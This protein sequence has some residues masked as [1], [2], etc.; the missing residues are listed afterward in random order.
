MEYIIYILAGISIVWALF[1]FAYKGPKKIWVT[2]NS[3][4]SIG[5]A[6]L[7][8][9]YISFWPLLISFGLSWGLKL[10]GFEPTN[11]E[12]LSGLEDSEKD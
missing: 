4:I 8:I 7:A 1:G 9:Y 6:V 2:I 12:V 10:L 11:A 5:F 3:L